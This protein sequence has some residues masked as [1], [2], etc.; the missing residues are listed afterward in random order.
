MKV[1]V[2]GSGT[3]GNGIAHTF[4][5]FAN[6]VSLVDI[7]E[8]ALEKGLEM[9]RKNLNRQLKKGTITEAEKTAI[10]S[11]INTFTDLQAA[12]AEAELVIEAAT[13]NPQIKLDLFKKLDAICSGSTVLASNTSSISI[14]L[15]ASAT[16][17]PD[18]VIG[19]H[20]MNPVPL[21]KLVEVIRGKATSDATTQ[22]VM[23]TAITLDKTPVVVN[24]APGFVANRILMPMINEAVYA[25]YERVA[26]VEEIDTVM[27]LGMAHPMGPLQLADYIGLDICLAILKVMEEGL[28]NPKYSPCPLLTTMI[29]DGHKGIKTGIGF[30]DYTGSGNQA[31]IASRFRE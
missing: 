1:T 3:M 13:E 2:I 26:G 21:M 16:K 10:L 24:D 31:V 23:K 30:Y 11:R 18:K 19:M 5:Q 9:I 4:A 22:M 8:E 28:N 12:V 6:Q 7:S 17:R 14:T 20:F 29:Q 27:K 15:L 25:L